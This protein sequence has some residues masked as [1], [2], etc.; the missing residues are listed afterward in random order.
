MLTLLLLLGVVRVVV[1]VWILA[2]VLLLACW[3]DTIMMPTDIIILSATKLNKAAAEQSSGAGHLSYTVLYSE[4][5]F[6]DDKR[7]TS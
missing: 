4:Y 2:A 7:M 3:R 5:V 6:L 1:R